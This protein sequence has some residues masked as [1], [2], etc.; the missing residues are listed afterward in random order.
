MVRVIFRNSGIGMGIL[1]RSYG[2]VPLW[3]YGIGF[4][5]SGLK[6]YPNYIKKI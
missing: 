2:D 5:K 1:L 3:K 6:M 4:Q